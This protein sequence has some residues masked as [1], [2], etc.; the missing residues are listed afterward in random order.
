MAL[1]TEAV[2]TC[3]LKSDVPPQ[4]IRILN[5]LM[6]PIEDPSLID[7][8]THPFFKQAQWFA[9]L[10]MDCAYFPGEPVSVFRPPEHADTYH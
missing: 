8:P 7:T 3:E 6:N 9:T 10:A 2:I 4:V 5:Y 1:W